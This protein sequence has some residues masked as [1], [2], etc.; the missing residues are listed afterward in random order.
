MKKLKLTNLAKDE[1]E[2]K[3]LKNIKGGGGKCKFSCYLVGGHRFR[4]HFERPKFSE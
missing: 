3:D 1:I 4:H 2:K